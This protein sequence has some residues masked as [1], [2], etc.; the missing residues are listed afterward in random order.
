[1]T[2]ASLARLVFDGRVDCHSPSR[3][4]GATADR[5]LEQSL[6]S[7]YSEALSDELLCRLRSMYASPSPAVDIRAFC[8]QVER[9]C[10]W[11]WTSPHV[12]ARFLWTAAWLN[13][14]VDR[15][16]TA[17]QLYDAFLQTPCRETH[18]RLLAY[19]NR[20]V[21]R[22]RLGRLEGVSDLLQAAIPESPARSRDGC[23]R[24]NPALGDLPVQ[25]LP[26]ACFNLLNLINVSLASSSLARAADE[27]L[28][29]FFCRLPEEGRAFWLGR[30]T[31]GEID[32]TPE[33]LCCEE[34]PDGGFA[35]LRDPTFRRLNTLTSCL[36]SRAKG[37]AGNESDSTTSSLSAAASRLI[38][39]ESRCGDGPS[40][41]PDRSSH[42]AYDY[43]AEAASLLLSDDIPSAL[44][45]LES[46]LA[47]AEQSVREELATIESRLALSR[48]ELVRSRL[49]A[50]RRILSSLNRRGRLAGLIARIDAQLE[51]V[52]CLQSQ[53]E[54]LHLQRA[55]VGL[56]SAVEQFDGI[57]DLCQ[58]QLQYEDLAG[59]IRR[60]RSGLAPQAGNEVAALL[61]E[62]TGRLDRHVR[63]LR[64]IETRRAIREPLRFLRRNWPA[65]W[66][67]PV[68]DSVYEALAQC[69]RSDPE[70]CVEDWPVLRD[71]LDAHQGQHHWHKVL[72]VVKAGEV[73]W[74]SVDEDLTRALV[75]KPDLWLAMAPLFA[76]SDSRNAGNSDL[77]LR[78]AQLL[79]RA[80]RQIGGP[81]NRC[82]EL[83]QC[84]ASTLSPVLE[85]DDLDAIAQVRQL[86]ERCLDHWPNAGAGLVGRADPR[87]PVRVFLESCE[88]ARRLVEARQ[89]LDA[90][91]ALWQEAKA[92][93]SDL[94]RLGLD[95]RDQLRRVATGFYLAACHEEDAPPV[96]RRV[97]AGL[98][99]WVDGASQEGVCRI[100]ES[101]VVQRITRL[102]AEVS[103]G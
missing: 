90:R 13:D 22:I 92:A 85:T 96:Q 48:Y 82:M 25:G 41:H 47:R 6:D 76:L 93:C 73:P 66:A 56:T 29:D 20:G 5:T 30:E 86:A 38:L 43:C 32:A 71:R 62:L 31:A 16:E 100:R 103:A 78:A 36:A 102:R 49:H 64:R 81:T 24:G 88:K 33:D 27:E 52:D 79:E 11:R 15:L 39:W 40:G 59:R 4:P 94:L 99:A 35:I 98:E 42:A 17:A 77:L 60:V 70:C 57:I 19:N 87:N 53:N 12:A 80:I 28:A 54:Q 72:A 97:L 68:A 61:D 55:C 8:E 37:F 89:A 91:P 65:D 58:A 26:A 3:T 45:R 21:L 63:R 50:Q 9:L 7:P 46:P 67:T 74:E 83:W 44:T 75:L 1:M 51:R 18:L 101:D 14:L 23:P 69:H 2:P 10:R 95:T 84:V 34:Q